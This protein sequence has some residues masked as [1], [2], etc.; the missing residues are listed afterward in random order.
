ML[1]GLCIHAL[2]RP[3]HASKRPLPYTDF[4]TLARQP[5][6]RHFFGV[7]RM[8][9]HRHPKLLGAQLSEM[10]ARDRP[11][12]VVGIPAVLTVVW[13]HRGHMSDSLV[14]GWMAFMFAVMA[15]R[16]LL[17][18]HWHATQADETRWRQALNWRLFVS[19][20][21][22]LGWGGSMLILNT[23][24]L[25][26]LTAFKVGTLTAA[27]GIMLNSMSVIFGVYLA[28]L[29]PCWLSLMGYIFFASGFLTPHDALICGVAVTIFGVVL[30]GSSFSIA[31][32]TRMFFLG[33]FELDDAL[34]Q[35]RE[36]HERE[37]ALSRQLAEQARRD[38]LTGAYNR[39]HLVEQLDYHCGVFERTGQPFSVVMIDID[40][41]KRINDTHGHDVGDVVL[42]GVTRVMSGSLREIDVFGRWGGE[43]FLCILAHTPADEALRCAERLR[44]HLRAAC[45]DETN[46]DLQVTASLGLA[47][48]CVGER[49][50]AVVKRCDLALYRAKAQGRDR[51]VS[52][53]PAQGPTED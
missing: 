32:L 52:A 20:F 4:E 8:V 31:R 6:G 16:L 25:D 10:A 2:A 38:A 9:A 28:F 46:P 35:T 45:L 26:V 40:H 33:R 49:G 47:T 21:Y 1:T 30:I 42:K 27:L 5:G 53:P 12:T 15:V 7:F 14:L 24:S 18:W 50:D 51:V 19:A 3:A 17:G 43:E 39:R 37:K 36:G 48:V 29:I 11:S 44:T 34:V 23:G 22:G 41:F 13:M